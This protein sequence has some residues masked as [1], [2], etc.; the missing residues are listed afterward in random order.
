MNITWV[1]RSFL[2]YRIPIYAEINRLSGNKLTVIY[3]A[4]VVPQR[5]QDKLKLIIGH[6]A[7]GLSGEFRISGKKNQALSSI[8]KKGIRIPIQP[9][10]LNEI[11]KSKPELILSD[12]FFQWTYAALWIRF[13]QKTPHL[14]LYE[15][16]KHTERNAGILRTIYRKMASK[17]IDHI[18]CNGTLSIEYIKALG[19]PASKISTGNMAA[20]SLTLET[21]VKK[22][23]PEL[24][25]EIKAQFALKGKI[26]IFVGRLV[27]LKGIDKLLKVWGNLFSK[28]AELNLLLVGD[29][30]QKAALERYVAEKK[31]VNVHFT[32]NVDYDSIHN[33]FAIAD[34]FIIPTLQDNWSL[35]VPEAMACGLPIICSKYNGCWPELVK[36]ENG[37]VFD[38]LNGEDFTIVLQKVWDNQEN[39]AAMG[40]KSIEIVQDYTPEKVAESIFNTCLIVLKK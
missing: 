29:G 1:T 7:I 38:P 25:E 24:K 18:S 37:W 39:W 23:M 12:G 21:N 19:Y 17:F 8:K 14:M 3:Y 33:Y 31:I 35:V 27:P 9:G 30:V 26:V 22:L 20:D 13:W 16:T 6:R 32:G 15:G 36:P 34:A 4:D 2:D 28:N 11:K 5:C 40:Q 10:L